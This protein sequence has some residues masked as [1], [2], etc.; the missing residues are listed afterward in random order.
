MTRPVISVCVF[1]L[2]LAL[3]EPNYGQQTLKRVRARPAEA[4]ASTV[5]SQDLENEI[6]KSP[7]GKLKISG[8]HVGLLGILKIQADMSLEGPLLITVGTHEA[9]VAQEDGNKNTDLLEV[10]LTRKTNYSQ[11]IKLGKGENLIQIMDAVD[12]S[13]KAILKW[14]GFETNQGKAPDVIGPV[15]K[16]E[17][18]NPTASSASGR[19]AVIGLHTQDQ[20]TLSVNVG[21]LKGPFKLI[22][23]DAVD[24]KVVSTKTRTLGRGEISFVE[25]MPLKGGQ[26]LVT[27]ASEDSKEKAETVTIGPWEVKGSETVAV[28]PPSAFAPNDF[29]VSDKGNISAGITR[30]NGEA[31]LTVHISDAVS[32]FKVR[33]LDGEG[34]EME[35]RTFSDLA[36]GVNDWSLNVRAGKGENTVRIAALDDS[37]AAELKLPAVALLKPAE[38][39]PLSEDTPE[40]DW[41]RV[42]GYFAGGVIFSKE[43]DDFSKSD[44]FL[45]FTLD[46][47]YIAHPWFK[48]FPDRKDEYGNVH[49]SYLFKD[50]NTFFDARLTSIPVTAKDTTGSAATTCNTPDCEAFITSKKAAM[51][52]AG[53][54]LPMYWHFTTWYREVPRLNRASRWEKNALFIAPLA[55]GGILTVTGN[56]QTAEAQQFGQDDVFNFYSFGAMLGH[57]RLHAR[58]KQDN[59]GH[60]LFNTF[61][62][63]IYES[64]PNIAPELI[65]WL[66]LSMGRWEN[67]E[68]EVP[69][70]QKDAMGQD[71][72]VRK[73]PWRYEALGR[74][75][76]PE[77]PFLIGFDGNFGKGPD[78]VRFIFGTRFDIGKILRTL[79][80]AGAQDTLGRDSTATPAKTN[81]P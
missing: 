13:E 78:D 63:P 65:S 17:N 9:I 2:L 26:Y 60:N 18:T 7:S 20:A 23:I 22:V 1:A 24:K 67:F 74:L 66:T 31:H 57:F 30:V 56:R 46:K 79:K 43:R 34:T 39:D 36:R 14:I 11:Q 28:Q 10:P 71:I 25:I 50:F 21:T 75:K 45:D 55:K 77:T 53:I 37:E 42:R 32:G 16:P 27:I 73:R 48:I 54:Y 40:Y 52:Q 62:K 72:K 19:L 15:P 59:W 33:V 58:R 80:V 69:T 44:I 3:A 51:M 35:S 4:A 61:G 68:I 5:A 47:N 49:K 41:G 6:S 76:I 29:R 70:G 12:R 8:A 38:T 81:A 64:N